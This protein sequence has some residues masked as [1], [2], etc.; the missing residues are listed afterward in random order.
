MKKY[1]LG[2]GSAN[3]DLQGFCEEKPLLKDSN[4]GEYNISVGGVCRN[5]L[6]VISRLKMKTFLITALTNDYYSEILKDNLNDLKIDYSYSKI[7]KTNSPIYLAIMDNLGD[8]HIAFNDM[9]AIEEIDPS[10]LKNNKDLID[11]AGSIVIDTNLNEELLEYIANK[12]YSDKV[13]IDPVSMGKC[14]KIKKIFNK[15][16]CLK[17][18]YYE[19]R[20]LSN[21]EDEKEMIEY[22]LSKGNK[23]VVITLGNKGSIFGDKSGIYTLD[24]IKTKVKSATG[25]G[26]SYMGALIYAMNRGYDFYKS[27]L[28]AVNVSAL[29][30]GCSGVIS[31]KISDIK[32]ERILNG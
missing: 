24:A 26:D 28:F 29:S 1:I 17:L 9:K 4:K 19:G 12:K 23:K 2:I 15:F 13:F 31:K 7:V 32:I 14:K 11:G 5:I 6:E 27:N 3:I 30:L 21:L 18:N 25:A 8:M 10:V 22:F 20:Y 16:Y